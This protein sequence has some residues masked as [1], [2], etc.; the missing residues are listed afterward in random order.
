MPVV[1]V[2]MV[3]FTPRIAMLLRFGP[4]FDTLS[5]SIP[6]TSAATSR[7]LLTPDS[8][9]ASGDRAAMLIGTLFRLSSGLV[10]VTVISLRASRAEFSPLAASPGA[11]GTA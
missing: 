11:G 9:I 6:G 5:N 7:M 1:E 10:G 2:P 8:A 4:Q 3:E